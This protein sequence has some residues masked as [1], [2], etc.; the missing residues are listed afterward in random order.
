M[1]PLPNE[2]LSLFLFFPSKNTREIIAALKVRWENKICLTEQKDVY[3]ETEI[4]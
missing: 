4:N 1:L 3:L 2:Q